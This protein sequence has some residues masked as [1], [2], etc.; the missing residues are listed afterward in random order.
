MDVPN[1]PKLSIAQLKCLDISFTTKVWGKLFPDA[2]F[3][4]NIAKN[5][6]V[7]VHLTN[8]TT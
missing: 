7:N 4:E 1:K 2:E 6:L 3:A 5:V 8:D